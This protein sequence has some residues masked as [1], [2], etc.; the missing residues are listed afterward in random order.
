MNYF[1]GTILEG[2]ITGVEKAQLNRLQL[3]KQFNMP[4]TCIYTSWNPYLYANAEK[5]NVEDDVFTMY[6]YFQQSMNEK[7]SIAKNWIQFWKDECRYELKFVPNSNDVRIYHNGMFTMYAHFFDRHYNKL[8][9]INYFD[10]NNKKIKRDMYDCRGFLSCSRILG[11]H[12]RVVLE[13]Y[14]SPHG[15]LKIQKYFNLNDNNNELTKIILY[16]S[17]STHYFN[18]ES[19]LIIYFYQCLYQH[20]DQFILDRPHELG[21][22]I[23][24]LPTIPVIAVLHS[25]HIVGVDQIKS[26]YKPIFSNLDRYQAIVVSTIQ[27]QLDVVDYINQ[28]IPVHVIPPGSA[29]SVKHDIDFDKK[30]NNRLISVA[31]LVP[32]KQI[33]HQIEAV[34]QLVTK[35]PSLKLDIFGHGSGAKEYQQLIV[36][37]NLSSNITIHDFSTNIKHEIATADMM[38]FTSI[39]EGFGLVILESIA[40]GT[41]VISYDIKYG[42]AE[43]IESDYN[44]FLIKPNDINSLVDKIDML[45]SDRQK[46][47][48]FSLNS[49]QT[50]ERFYDHVIAE[51]WQTII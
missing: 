48:Q 30:I 2:K 41:P 36:D 39:M 37:N 43:I 23:N 17:N 28:Q 26:Y 9:Y 38:I 8:N 15:D 27:Q 40:V 4:A 24:Q 42:P 50:A 7:M 32:G 25:T 35:Y 45:L 46:L 47:T 20:G 10:I 11:D 1:L 13:N 29:S 22:I 12:Q 44:G 33:K 19:E 31:R 34:K 14:F 16:D 5:F 21:Q 18:N 49:L 51:K 6:D 3:F